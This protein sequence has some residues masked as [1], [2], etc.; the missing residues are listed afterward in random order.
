[1]AQV[2]IPANAAN[3]NTATLTDMRPHGLG[4]ELPVAAGTPF[5]SYTDQNSVVWI[6]KG[7]VAGGAW[8]RARDYLHARIYRAAALNYMLVSNS[9]AF[10]TADYDVY[11]LLGGGGFV[12]PL[13]GL[14]LFSVR[15][16]HNTGTGPANVA[17]S[18][19]PYLYRNGTVVL[20]GPLN[21]ARGD[22]AIE[23]GWNVRWRCNAGDTIL[24]YIGAPHDNC[25]A[26]VG[27]LNGSFA[28]CD[29]LGP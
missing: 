16:G 1:M 2:L 5:Q 15:T 11:G 10:D 25:V 17:D 4:V 19:R 6:A 12:V 29:W 13:A 27:G 24:F 28:E 23:Y 21:T 9:C 8:R 22:G 14:Y 20:N 18:G 7:A 26:Q 3:L